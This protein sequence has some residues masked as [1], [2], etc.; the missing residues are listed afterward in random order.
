MPKAKKRKMYYSSYLKEKQKNIRA[1]KNY[2]PKS[3][4]LSK[5][6]DIA[7]Q[8]EWLI[9]NSVLCALLTDTLT[10]L[11][12]QEEEFAR[13]GKLT[14]NEKKKPHHK[15]MRYNPLVIKWSC[16]I[17]SKCHRKGYEVVRSI[18]PIDTWE[19]VKQYRQAASTT[20]PISQENLNLVN[21]LVR[22]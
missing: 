12:K 5:L 6:M 9:E 7:I 15:G 13:H 10:S 22:K 3:S 1:P 17:A 8:N 11:K 19:T 21:T 16:M 4:D 20:N 14:K 18:L 2:N